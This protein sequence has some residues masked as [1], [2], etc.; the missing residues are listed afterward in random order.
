MEDQT[1]DDASVPLHARMTWTIAQ[2]ALV[3]GI[4]EK[5][6]RAAVARGDLAHFTLPGS[7]T[8][9]IRREDLHDWIMSL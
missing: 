8:R 1:H 5:S 2:A 6:V 9:R 4:P 7:T 3:A